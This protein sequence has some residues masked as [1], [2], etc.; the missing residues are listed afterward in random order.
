MDFKH[1]KMLLAAAFGSF[2]GVSAYVMAAFGLFGPAAAQ[3]PGVQV[4]TSLVGTEY[5]ANQNAVV[6]QVFSTS[7]LAGYARGQALLYTTTATN[8]APATT[9]ESTIISYSLPANTLN[10]GTKL[11]IKASFSAAADSN[12]KT[13][14]CY[15]GASVIS[16]STL[17]TNNKNGTCDLIV[18][19]VGASKQIVYANMLVDTTQITGYV[20]TTGT[21]TDTSA[22]GIK[23]TVT[24]ATP[25]ANEI[26]VNDMSVERLGN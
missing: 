23:V 13:I 7:S 14:K 12:N 21:D 1:R 10:V 11:W 15:F 20:N 17:S 16:S 5:I 24:A 25:V 22:I 3:I 18:T 26:I 8:G 4:L 2:V 6:S 9:A 19:K